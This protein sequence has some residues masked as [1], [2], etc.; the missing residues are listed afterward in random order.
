MSLFRITILT[1]LLSTPTFYGQAFEELVDEVLS[2][3]KMDKLK[4]RLLL[5]KVEEKPTTP[6]PTST[7]VQ[8]KAEDEDLRLENIVTNGVTLQGLDK[9]T[10]R[11]FIID[12]KIGQ[13]IEFGPLTIVVQH[14]RK[15]PPRKSPGIHGFHQGYGK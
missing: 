7:E 4:L 3:T 6:P 14:C 5:P 11:V 2:D 13:P 10:A 8:A 9:Q 12:A 1:L 15:G